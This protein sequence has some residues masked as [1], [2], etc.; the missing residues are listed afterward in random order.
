MKIW[1]KFLWIIHTDFL[2]FVAGK[3]SNCSIFHWETKNK[4]SY[5]KTKFTQYFEQTCSH[6]NVASLHIPENI[7][8]EWCSFDYGYNFCPKYGEVEDQKKVNYVVVVYM[9]P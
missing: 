4:N 8:L 5:L 9:C 7:S 2:E 3:L 6:I 1:K